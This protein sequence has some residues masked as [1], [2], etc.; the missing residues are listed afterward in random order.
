MQFFRGYGDE[1]ERD[2]DRHRKQRHFDPRRPE[3]KGKG[4]FIFILIY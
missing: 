3:E 1:R 4:N 2:R